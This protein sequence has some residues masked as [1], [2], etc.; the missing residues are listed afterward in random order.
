MTFVDSS[1]WYASVYAGDRHNAAAKQL[2]KEAVRLITTDHVL[3]ET[4]LLINSRFDHRRADAFWGCTSSFP[5]EVVK[6]SAADMK[7]AWTIGQQFSDQ[8]F[9]IVDRT[10]FVVMERLGINRV[11]SFDDDFVIYRMRPRRDRAF[12]VLR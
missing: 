12:E 1:A 8:T 11:I 4:W 7:K 10:S 5:L 9:S 6:V 3:V 2:I